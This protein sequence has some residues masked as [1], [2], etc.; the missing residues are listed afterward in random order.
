MATVAVKDN[1]FKRSLNVIWQLKEI[2]LISIVVVGAL[3]VSGFFDDTPEKAPEYTELY[4]QGE[5][6]NITTVNG[7][8]VT[9]GSENVVIINVESP[10]NNLS[11]TATGV[12]TTTRSTKVDITVE[13]MRC[14][15]RLI[16]VSGVVLDENKEKGLE[17]KE[18][19]VLG[20]NQKGILMFIKPVIQ[21]EVVSNDF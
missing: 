5:I 3:L 14:N 9:P 19:F 18:N 11:C 15:G 16:R 12:A 4:Q 10:A 6:L 1:I 17:T 20:A 7:L 2:L 8:T 13:A 21:G